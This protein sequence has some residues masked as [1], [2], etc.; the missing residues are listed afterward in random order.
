MVAR[1]LGTT[2][3]LAT[4]YFWTVVTPV[5]AALGLDALVRQRRAARLLPL[6]STLRT[7]VV[8]AFVFGLLAL[9]LNDSG[10]VVTALMF[11]YVGPLLVLR[12]C[13]AG[14]HPQAQAGLAG[15]LA[16]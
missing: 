6:G 15:S 16:G 10:A 8:A 1:R 13:E 14:G 12:A 9:A 2:L 11:V 7:G 3:R 5:L 4:A